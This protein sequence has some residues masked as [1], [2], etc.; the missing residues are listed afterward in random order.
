MR[1][2]QPKLKRPAFEAPSLEIHRQQRGFCLPALCAF[3]KFDGVNEQC[4]GGISAMVDNCCDIHGYTIVVS[5][6]WF[7]GYK[8]MVFVIVTIMGCF[9]VL[10][11][12]PGCKQLPR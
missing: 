6:F 4:E 11:L 5:V 1:E 10:V 2:H 9:C 8:E 7:G 12:A 3:E